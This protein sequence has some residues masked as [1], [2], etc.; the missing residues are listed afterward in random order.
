MPGVF[1]TMPPT[2]P[3]GFEMI[4]CPGCGA[5]HWTFTYAGKDWILDPARTITIV[6][7]VQCGL[8]FTNPRPDSEHIG[9]YY[10]STYAPY[11]RQRGEIQRDTDLSTTV[12]TWVL[13]AAYGSPAHKPRGWRAV[14]TFLIS[15]FKPP[16]QFGFGI[17]F[18]GDGRLLDFGC[19]NGTFL[20][21]MNAIGW[22]GMGLDLSPEAV[23]AVKDSGIPA[24]LGTLPHPELPKNHFDVITMRQALEHVPSPVPVLNAAMENLRPGGEL[25]IEVPNFASF[26]I[27]YFEEAALILDLPRHLLHFTPKTLK[28]L[29]IAC[30]YEDVRIKIISRRG[31]MLKSYRQIER[32]QPKKWDWIFGWKFFAAIVAMWFGYQG[33]GNELIA[34][35]RKPG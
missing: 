11:Q 20:R 27:E 34:T 8:H 6:R 19:G 35:G 5:D 29:M 24:L 2:L 28:N 30:G 25:V 3:K 14:V 32:R 10:A 23:T 22:T 9:E 12:R 16:S 1:N 13:S 17:P 33:K 4:N 18:R 15:L 21:R 31:W 7:C 26:D